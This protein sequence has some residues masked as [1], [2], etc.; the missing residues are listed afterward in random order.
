MLAKI[1]KSHE[2]SNSGHYF[3]VGEIVELLEVNKDSSE[4]LF[5]NGNVD[6]YLFAD[7]FEALDESEK[8]EDMPFANNQKAMWL[9]YE[10][11]D[12]K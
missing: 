4:F 3:E 7:E 11:Q 12:Y 6:Q 2:D 8:N 5:T 9:G 1:I 10:G